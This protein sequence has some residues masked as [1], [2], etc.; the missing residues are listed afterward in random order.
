[1]AQSVDRLSPVRRRLDGT[2]QGHIEGASRKVGRSV[3]WLIP[4]EKDAELETENPPFWRCWFRW[5]FPSEASG[6]SAYRRAHRHRNSCGS[7]AAE[8][9][10]HADPVLD[11][12]ADMLMVAH[13]HAASHT[14]HHLLP[15][16]NFS[17][18]LGNLVCQC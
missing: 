13:C 10:H 3:G 16:L 18:N 1:M 7:N 2:V 8:H 17:G 14:V 4:S 6:K 5:G 9:Y 11:K 12:P 15:I